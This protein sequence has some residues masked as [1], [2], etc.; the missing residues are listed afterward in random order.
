MKLALNLTESLDSIL[1]RE[2]LTLIVYLEHEFTL[3]QELSCTAKAE[4]SVIWQTNVLNTCIL[5]HFY[6]S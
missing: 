5:T 6:T 3:N 1:S 2:F 4:N